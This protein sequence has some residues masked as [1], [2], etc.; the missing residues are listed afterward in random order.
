M[1]TSQPRKRLP[2][3]PS[4]E[5]LKKQARR[6][7]ARQPSMQLADAQHQLAREYGCRN[8]AELAHVVETMSRGATEQT[9]KND[10]EPLPAAANRND[11]DGVRRILTDGPFTQHDLDLALARAVIGFKQR[12]E[13]AELLLEHGADP[14]GQYGSNYGPIVLANGECVDPDGLQFLIDNGA[15]VKFG[16]IDTKYGQTS[17]MV[18]ILGTYYRGRNEDKHR[19]IEILLKHGVR[20]P[21]DVPPE[22]MMIHRGH[23]AEL[24][25][26]LDRDPA[27]LRRRYTANRERFNSSHE[28]ATLLHAAVE[29]GELE[30]VDLLIARGADLNA[31]A[32]FV[33]GIGGHTPIFQVVASCGQGNRY[34]LEHLSK[35]YGPRIDMTVRAT[36][37]T[38]DDV[39]YRDVTP[40]EFAEACFTED[41]PTYRRA[42][43]RELDILR[44]L[45]LR[46]A[47]RQNDLEAVRNLIDRGADPNRRLDGGTTTL[48][49]AVA[50]GSVAMVELLQSR[51][52]L[53]WIE[54]QSG[55]KPID[56]VRTNT[57]LDEATRQRMT[58]LLDLP[59][60]GDPN[61]R[62]AIA[63]I[64]AGNLPK[65]R[66][67]LRKHPYLATMHSGDSG[68]FAGGYFAN[69][70]LLWYVAENPIRNDTLPGNICDLAEAIIDAGAN[71]D[72]ITY[73]TA[74]VASG[75]VPRECRL[76]IPLIET[77]VRRGGDPG[78]ALTAAVQEHEQQAIEALLRLGAKPDLAAAAGLG[79]LD[80]L[81]EHLARGDQQGSAVSPASSHKTSMQAAMSLAAQ[82]GQTQAMKMLLDH[83]V[84]PN[85]PL[86]LAATPLHQA[87]WHDR[88]EIVELLLSRGAD[89]TVRDTRFDA[90]P[91]G[92]AAHNGH[93]EL[94]ELLRAAEVRR[95]G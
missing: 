32:D 37:R 74:L 53:A 28:I 38:V 82:Y 50:A 2:V 54:D 42:S 77:L 87:A 51:G 70:A 60:G 23:V 61:F 85:L 75:R 83:G 46:Q 86:G 69:P 19:Y 91:A 76:Q 20:V 3:N 72:D 68:S 66:E 49:L 62:D 78:G 80:E 27:L 1:S 34:V 9:P 10:F 11:I 79:R 17:P 35:R 8:W 58:E 18:S 92:W 67:L 7:A 63:A 73:T 95:Q 25:A 71:R 56:H 40:L 36:I 64:D 43:Q 15:D 21:D 5:H 30:C 29:F 4:I 45:T 94:A 55:Q 89:P 59:K 47:V 22:F 48:H 84:D 93:P 6:I 12:H 13:I 52:A 14:N 57:E 90:T 31:R 39:V 41:T 81:R 65:L 24:I 16:D 88:R 26:A 44:A 33:D